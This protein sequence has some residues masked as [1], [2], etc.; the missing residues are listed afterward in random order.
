MIGS[1]VK[2]PPPRS[3]EELGGALQEPAVE[4]EDVPRVRLAAA[5]T[6]GGRSESCRY[7]TACLERSSYT[8]SACL[9]L[10][11]EV[12]AHGSRR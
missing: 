6:G 10:S 1:A 3:L 11:P 4:V 2:D 7:A 8:M 12:L 5:G 9:P